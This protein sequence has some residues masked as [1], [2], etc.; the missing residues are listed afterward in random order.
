MTA[1]SPV[2]KKPSWNAPSVSSGLFQ[3]SLKIIGPLAANSPASDRYLFFGVRDADQRGLAIRDGDA[4]RE[5]A[6][7]LVHRGAGAVGG[8]VGRGVG[9]GKAVD[10]VDVNA[11]LLLKALGD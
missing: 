7:L 8:G 3:Y 5:C 6:A 1:T 10:V 9:L 4:D 11:E 2:R